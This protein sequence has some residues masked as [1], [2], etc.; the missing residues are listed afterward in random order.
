MTSHLCSLCSPRKLARPQK[1]QLQLLLAVIALARM[2]QTVNQAEI[3]S[4]Q[5]H[6]SCA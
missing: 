1:Q 4:L 5:A 3:G 2:V 6:H